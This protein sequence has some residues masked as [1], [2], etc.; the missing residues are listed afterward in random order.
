MSGM[1]IALS[2]QYLC[3]MINEYT[4]SV[5]IFKSPLGIRKNVRNKSFLKN[6][7]EQRQKLNLKSRMIVPENT[8]KNDAQ[9]PPYALQASN[10]I[11][12]GDSIYAK[13]KFFQNSV[14]DVNDMIDL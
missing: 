12:G 14:N 1:V 2:K 10:E 6:S 9:K 5:I 3:A 11:S 7:F 13:L 8:L 4:L